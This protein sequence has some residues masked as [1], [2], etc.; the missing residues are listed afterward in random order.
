M[1]DSRSKATKPRRAR[2]QATVLFYTFIL[3]FH[4]EFTYFRKPRHTWFAGLWAHTKRRRLL[5]ALSSKLQVIAPPSARDRLQTKLR[6]SYCF[7]LHIHSAIPSGVYRFQETTPYLI[8]NAPENAWRAKDLWAALSSQAASRCSSLSTRWSTNKTA[9][10]VS[11][12][13]F[14]CTAGVYISHQSEKKNNNIDLQYFW[15]GF[16]VLIRFVY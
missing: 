12:S 10:R 16:S 13:P 9:Y 3:Q 2:M 11:T 14:C 15:L 4:L 8:H 5:A 1:N 6:T 7:A